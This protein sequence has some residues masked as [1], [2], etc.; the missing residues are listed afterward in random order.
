VITLRERHTRQSIQAFLDTPAGVMMSAQYGSRERAAAA[1]AENDRADQQWRQQQAASRL[2]RYPSRYPTFYDALA[3]V[4]DPVG[5]GGVWMTGE[6]DDIVAKVRWISPSTGIR[7]LGPDIENG[8]V[9]GVSQSPGRGLEVADTR[10]PW[11]RG[12]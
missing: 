11:N 7:N 12:E 9:T 1:M 8:E 5:G 3:D 4:P 10:P 6:T 2:E